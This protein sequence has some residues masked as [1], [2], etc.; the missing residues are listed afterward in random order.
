MAAK[1]IFLVVVGAA[2][3]YTDIKKRLIL[4]KVTIPAAAAGVVLN[5]YQ[6]GWKGVW[7][8]L[9]GLALGFGVSFLIALLGGYGGGDVKM[10]AAFGAIGGIRFILY[11]MMYAAVIDGAV[12]VAV[13]VLQKRL[14]SCLSALSEWVARTLAGEKRP[15]P[16]FGS[17][18]HAPSLTLGGLLAW[19]VVFL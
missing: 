2:C 15:L 14:W 8:S 6:A 12:A 18:P 13:L 9:G 5:A 19:A 11:C 3:S 17:I 16:S 4:N 1:V 10:T 7:D